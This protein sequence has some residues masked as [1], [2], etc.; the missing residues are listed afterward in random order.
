MSERTI[1]I[2][3]PFSWKRFFLQWEWFLILLFVII[4]VVNSS[5]SP[6]YFSLDTFLNTPMNFLDK[7]FLVLP[8]IM[9]IVLG[10]IDV[11]VASTVA[12][13]SVI[14]AVTYNA[15]LPMPLAMG[16]CIL[17]G[18]LCGLFNGFMIVK[19]KELSPTIITLAT[20][21]IF[22]GVAYVILEDRASG[23]FPE[24][25]S[26]LAWGYVG[27]VPFILI[28]FAVCALAFAVL[29]HRT[30]FGRTLFAMGNNAT[31][32][33]YSGVETNKVLVIT[34]ALAGL[35]AGITG[36]FLTSRMGS[37]RP[38]VASGYEL[39]VIAMV[40]LGGVSTSGGKGRI[41]GP[42]L[43]ILI[44]GFLN[45]GLGLVNISAQVLL[46]ILGV[47]LIVSVMILNMRFSKRHQKPI[48]T[49]AKALAAKG[50]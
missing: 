14:M 30:R 1:T 23:K 18:A 8:M 20:M 49:K 32:C 42:L 28:A 39:D 50:I 12:L 19:F 43:A 16:L 36:L 34:S 21:S 7:A 17:V 37:T 26:F 24:W 45:Y 2:E 15:G 47:L 25:F 6:Y 41:T 11:S 4:N 44:I 9:I 29:I 13:S 31:A 46:I 22:R 5:L 10:N 48:P 38:N 35:M 27:K 33:R 3:K 40:V